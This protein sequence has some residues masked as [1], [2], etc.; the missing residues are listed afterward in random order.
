[1]GQGLDEADVLGHLVVGQA[2]LAEGH[3]VVGP[4][5]G[6]GGGDH[7]GRADLAVEVVGDA[8]HGHL[9]H[10]RVLG[11]EGLDLGRVDVGPA[12][13]VGVGPAAD[14]REVAPLV[15]GGEVAGVEPA[16]DD[17]LGGGPLVPEVAGHDVAA[18]HPDD[19]HLAR[20]HRPAGLG[21]AQLDLVV[22]G[23]PAHSGDHV[24][25][26][27]PEVGPRGA[28]DR[29]GEAVGGDEGG[30]GHLLVDAGHEAF[31]GGRAA[32]L[33]P[34]DAREVSLLCVGVAQG[35]LV[36][37]GHA[38]EVRAA[39]GHEVVHEL[40]RLEGV[41]EHDGRA[42]EE[43]HEGVHRAAERPEERGGQDG[44]V[45]WPETQ[46]VGPHLEVLDDAP[47]REHRP[48]R[49]AGRPRGVDDEGH[50]VAGHL[51]RRGPATGAQPLDLGPGGHA[52]GP[53]ALAETDDLPQ[54]REAGAPPA[55][56]VGLGELGHERLEERPA[57]VAE[58]GV[59][60]DERAHL[61]AR[62]DRVELALTEGGVEGHEPGP[63][64]GHRVLD[65]QPVEAVAEEEAHP[66]ARA[67][68]EGGQA[69]R[70][71]RH[72]V[73]EVGKGLGGAAVE[74]PRRRAEAHHRP[75]EGRRDRR[76]GGALGPR[77]RIGP[78]GHAP[79]PVHAPWSCADQRDDRPAGRSGA[80][81]GGVEAP[82]RPGLT[83]RRARRPAR[84]RTAS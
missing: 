20:G 49:R 60:D 81:A 79:L 3:D 9:G 80:C 5:V 35:H 43:G 48:L 40:A 31:G 82:L 17:G 77:R 22:G 73:T 57:L 53:R 23:R 72:P 19:A 83:T 4:E 11:Q 18:A 78:V 62:H 75:G 70:E 65:L 28:D 44:T 63:E 26:G 27:C 29:L 56:R 61:G 68:A 39:V 6:P 21:V 25:V 59:A 71:D 2:F 37:G 52:P 74:H 42:A 58:H 47:V 76:P 64:R 66:V 24:R 69:G 34:A 14:D 41:L 50:V 8:D 13:L 1:M 15:H 84:G 46:V 51:G 16:V 55:P 33:D 67:Y 54:G 7:E 32:D 30:V 12:P 10:R 38:L 45:T 36:V